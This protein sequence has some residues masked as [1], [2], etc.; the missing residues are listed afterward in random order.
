MHP[1]SLPLGSKSCL[2]CAKPQLEC[3]WA[4]QLNEASVWGLS[5]PPSTA[6]AFGNRSLLSISSRKAC[7]KPPNLLTA[8]SVLSLREWLSEWESRGVQA[9]FR[10]LLGLC[11]FSG[12]L[13]VP[14]EQRSVLASEKGEFN[15]FCFTASSSSPF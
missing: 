13:G 11:Q 15:A 14:L 4:I 2:V 3:N 12:G 1:S 7:A 8:Q 10:A 9:I 6:S 5:L